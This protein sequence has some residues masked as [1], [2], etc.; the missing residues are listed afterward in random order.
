MQACI[1]QKQDPVDTPQVESRLV[2]DVLA[3]PWGVEI[4]DLLMK[5]HPLRTQALLPQPRRAQKVLVMGLGP[6]GFSMMHY[7]WMRGYAV[8]GMDGA[9]LE[10][11]PYGDVMRPVRDFSSLQQP[12]SRRVKLGFGGVCEYGITSRWDKNLLSVIYLSLLRRQH[13]H[14]LGQCR[15]GGTITVE[16]AWQLGY[17]HMVLALGAGLPRA[18][19]IP[20][21][22]A[23]G[24]MQ[25]SDFLMQLHTLGA[26]TQHHRTPLSLQL[27][28][29]VI[30]AGLTAVDTATEAQAYYLHL[31]QLV[32][33]RLQK[34]RS[35]RGESAIEAAFSPASYAQ[36]Q[37]WFTHGE[38]VVLEKRA[39]Q[40]AQRAKDFRPLLQQ[41][42]GVRLVYRRALTDA[43]AYR[44]N[45][46]ELQAALDAG[47]VFQ[48]HTAVTAVE[49]DQ[50]GFVAHMR[51]LRPWDVSVQ[52][53]DLHL[54][55]VAPLSTGWRCH[56][57]KAD[58]YLLVG[59]V[60]ALRVH[61]VS[62][63]TTQVP[64]AALAAS[65]VYYVVSAVHANAIDV[66][67]WTGQARVTG[68]VQP[69]APQVVALPW[70][71]VSMP[72]K[73]IL[74]AT[75]SVP[76]TAYGFEH[77]DQFAR[78]KD[79]YA[80]R[81]LAEDG[82]TRLSE[83]VDLAQ[84]FFTSYEAHNRRVS[85]IGDL[86]PHYHGS[87]VKALASSQHAV[88]AI[89]QHLAALAVKA[90]LIPSAVM[91]HDFSATVVAQTALSDD[92]FLLKI[93]APWQ[94]AKFRPGCL[95][96]LQPYVYGP[97]GRPDFYG[98]EAL[99][100]QPCAVDV[101]GATLSFVLLRNDPVSAILAS[102]DVGDVLSMMG[103]TGVP[104]SKH[105]QGQT[106]LLATDAT[107]LSSALLYQ[108]YYAQQADRVDF[109]VEDTPQARQLLLA[110]ALPFCKVN[111]VDPHAWQAVFACDLSIYTT[112][113]LH[114]AVAFV[115]RHYGAYGRRAHC[116]NA[117]QWMG[118]VG[119]PMQ[120]M[121][122]GICAQC[123]QWQIDPETGQRTKAVFACS[124]QDQPLEMVDLDHLSQRH[125]AVKAMVCLHQQWS[126]MDVLGDFPEGD[127][128]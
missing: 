41:W 48:S 71:D 16:D 45:H 102:L 27:P 121:L 88:R 106:L 36:L 10:P 35:M 32:Y 3:L 47:I 104:L 9:H 115:K 66:V 105:M 125:E 112:I 91:S 83:V 22:L 122:K 100:A 63:T 14:M 4:Y 42:G 31:V 79:F 114:G 74:V 19:A 80:L 30:G 62:S 26:Q 85:V 17:D 38:A 23:P 75:G 54:R 65:S 87:V 33:F 56:I 89:D 43:P 61:Q 34:L 72:V 53:P 124:W 99:D 90:K 120:C 103:P 39:A 15:F 7:L 59:M 108:Q 92:A 84:S 68:D 94:V 57:P 50:Q 126:K 1:Y 21:S 110:L 58:I 101:E 119:G 117:A 78:E 77:R 64:D 28:C 107:R 51:C 24:M 40:Q 116:A 25:A 96:K 46:D 20:H 86:H 97:S 109:Y 8:T 67:L 82:L 73:T 2:H 70:Q 29:V 123:L 12:L 93:R 55:E 111:W 127:C 113:M 98:C 44:S 11:W 118:Y 76:N 6:A 69:L 5:W 60:L 95:F 18:L 81:A 13:C 52:W 49:T 37:T 128:I